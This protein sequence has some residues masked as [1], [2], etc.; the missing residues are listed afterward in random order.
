MPERIQ[1]DVEHHSYRCSCHWT[2]CERLDTLAA[3]W[4]VGFCDT[5]V[6][7]SDAVTVVRTSDAVTQWL[8]HQTL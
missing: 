2:V 4:T 6:R 1:E 8:G 3:Q 5:V 7:T